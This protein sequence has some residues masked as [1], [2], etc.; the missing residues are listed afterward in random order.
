[1]NDRVSKVHNRVEI[2]LHRNYRYGA[3]RKAQ[4]LGLVESGYLIVRKIEDSG[5]PRHIETLGANRSL[6]QGIGTEDEARRSKECVATGAR[7]KL[8]N[9]GVQR[10]T[11]KHSLRF[12]DLAVL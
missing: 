6:A 10:R 2:E 1:V 12:E 9:R 7:G 11:G 3:G 5:S 4:S 8:R